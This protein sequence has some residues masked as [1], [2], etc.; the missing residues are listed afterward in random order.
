MKGGCTDANFVPVGAAGSD[1]VVPDFV[2]SSL[3]V[4]GGEVSLGTSNKKFFSRF[5]A[6]GEHPKIRNPAN[7]ATPELERKHRAIAW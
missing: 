4:A 3:D 2:D 7:S 6:S 5:R 1:R